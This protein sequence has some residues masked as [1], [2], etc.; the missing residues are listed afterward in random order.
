MTTPSPFF[1]FY[2][3]KPPN[4]ELLSGY[5]ANVWGGG[6]IGG[7]EAQLFSWVFALQ[8]Q[9][10]CGNKLDRIANYKI[11]PSMSFGAWRWRCGLLRNGEGNA[12]QES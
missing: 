3:P 7:K 12:T 5:E 4:D 2:H 9:L 8:N 10:H 11:P 1:R 6:T